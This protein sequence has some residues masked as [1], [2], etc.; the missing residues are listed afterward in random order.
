[1]TN[2]L[3]YFEASTVKKKVVNRWSHREH[4]EHR[5]QQTRQPGGNFI[6]LFFFF[7]THKKIE[8]ESNPF[9]LRG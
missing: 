8:L 3:A 6:N 9:E 1:V 4:R 5:E 7:Y 2:S